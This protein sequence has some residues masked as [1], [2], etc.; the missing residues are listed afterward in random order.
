MFLPYIIGAHVLSELIYIRTR[1][2]IPKFYIFILKTFVP[3]FGFIMF[4]FSYTGEFSTDKYVSSTTGEAKMTS[5]HLWGFRMLIILPTLMF[6]VSIFFI[7]EDIRSWEECIEEQYGIKFINEPDTTVWT[8]LFK[9]DAAYEKTNEAQF[10][11]VMDDPASRGLLDN[12]K[13]QN[14]STNK[15]AIDTSPVTTTN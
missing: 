10:N 14:I 4:H 7:P 6:V 3:L 2:R 9:N 8:Y 11:A 13:G 1:T 12:D 5:G 15:V